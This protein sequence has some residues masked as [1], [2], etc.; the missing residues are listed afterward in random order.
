[1]NNESR[2]QG[3]RVL[4]G[5]LING[6]PQ[7]QV[8]PPS[9]QNADTRGTSWVVMP[10]AF[11]GGRQGAAPVTVPSPAIDMVGAVLGEHDPSQF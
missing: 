1:M 11:N 4:R 10:N 9:P 7:V 3:E 2:A 5:D 6:E 8:F